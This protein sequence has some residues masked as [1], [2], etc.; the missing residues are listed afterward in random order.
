MLKW[1]RSKRKTALMR[2]VVTEL[3]GRLH[4]IRDAS[5]EDRKHTVKVGKSLNSHLLGSQHRGG[6]IFAS[7]SRRESFLHGI[8][9]Q[10]RMKNSETNLTTNPHSKKEKEHRRACVDRMSR[11]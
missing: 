10:S 2:A 1:R 9:L 4:K 6:F 7:A 8:T 11:Q 3:Q 5:E